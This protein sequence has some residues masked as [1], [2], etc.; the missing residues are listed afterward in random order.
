VNLVGDENQAG[1][2]VRGDKERVDRRCAELA[3]ALAAP[4]G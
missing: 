4:M 3:A 2:A 1:D